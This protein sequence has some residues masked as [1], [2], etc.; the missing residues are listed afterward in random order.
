MEL[1]TFIAAIIVSYLIGSFS[2]A[3]WAGKFKGMDIREH[4]SGNLGATNAARVLGKQWFFV[5]FFGDVFKGLLPVLFVMHSG[6]EWLAVGP[7]LSLYLPLSCGLGAVLGHS[8][9]VFHG[10]KGGKAV[11]TSL[12][13][14]VALAPVS[15]GSAFG[16]WVVVWLIIGSIMDIKRSDAVGPASIVAVIACP[17][18]HFCYY[19]KT[20]EM[21][22][23]A[24]SIIITL[25]CSFI[26]IRH[27]SNAVKFMQQVKGTYQEPQKETQE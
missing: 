21:P 14:V 10:I 25:I 11:A 18:I 8:F 20:F 7:K 24:S 9:T 12:G 27:R 1:L 4:G 26:L 19:E 2:F 6:F 13:V 17:I 15:G 16:I 23:L 22:M 3:Y 5:V